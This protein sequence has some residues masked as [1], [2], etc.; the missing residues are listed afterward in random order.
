MI[1]QLPEGHCPIERWSFVDH[2]VYNSDSDAPLRAAPPNLRARARVLERALSRVKYS[3]MCT[4][5][6]TSDPRFLVGPDTLIKKAQMLAHSQK[7]D[8]ILA[9][10]DSRAALDPIC[11]AFAVELFRRHSH[12]IKL[13]MSHDTFCQYRGLCC[14]MYDLVMDPDPDPD[15]DP[16]CDFELPP[17]RTPS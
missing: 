17:D 2:C 13:C 12:A 14:L 10:L 16:R 6:L 5:N 4:R 3:V 7:V 1:Y 11:T 9:Y 8:R 15:D